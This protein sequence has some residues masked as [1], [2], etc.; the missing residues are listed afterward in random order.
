METE[1]NL[2]FVTADAAGPKHLLYKLSRAKFEQIV[3][4]LIKRSIEP[5]K[6][7]LADAGKTVDTDQ[8]DGDGRRSDA[9][10]R[11]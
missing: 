5:C 4:D 2:P 1:I 3:D 7:A 11:R 10:C 9:H 8:R 6:K